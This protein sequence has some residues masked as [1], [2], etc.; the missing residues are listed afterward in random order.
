[1]IY[2]VEVPLEGKPRAWFAFEQEDLAR[3]AHATR[4]REGWTIFETATPRQLL[5][6]CGKTP[7]T[8]GAAAEHAEIFQLADTYGWDTTLYRADY[9]C[10][11][12]QYR[13]E[14]IAELDACFA[15]IKHDLKTCR[16]YLSNE[17][18][19]NELYRD[20]IYA[21]REGFFAHMALREQLISMEVISDDL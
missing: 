2:V 17:E 14:P 20:S 5:Q 7:E 16:M 8:Q 13:P 1:M 11:Q 4:K 15:A 9:L 21:G 12:Q 3:K 6:D 18:A 19:A 10:G